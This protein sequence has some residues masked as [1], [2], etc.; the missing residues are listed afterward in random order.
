MRRTWVP[1]AAMIVCGGLAATYFL[2][3]LSRESN[4]HL[5]TGAVWSISLGLWAG[6]AI[7]RRG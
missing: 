3:A 1:V 6:W 4:L 7:S 5:V 2:L